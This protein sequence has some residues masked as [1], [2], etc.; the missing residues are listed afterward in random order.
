MKKNGLLLLMILVLGIVSCSNKNNPAGGA[1]YD[2]SLKV[3]SY[4]VHHCNPPSKPD[5]IDIDAIAN[6]IKKENPDLV[7]LQ[8]IDVKVNRSGKID[9]AAEIA[10]RAGFDHFYFSKAIDH[11]GG[12]YGVAIL[13]KYPVS[14]KRT[15]RLPTEPST[16]GEPRVLSLV[17]ISLPGGKALK[18]GSTHFDAQKESV[19]RLLQAK[20]IN[21]I[22]AGIEQPLIIAGDFNATEESEVMK[23]IREEFGLTCTNCA[24]TIPV[25]TPKKT[26][27][28]IAFRPKQS[29]EISSHRVIGEHYASDHLPVISVLKLR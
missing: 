25:V 24:P 5:L 10:K 16:K 14:E 15:F 18:F 26:I 2:S 7:A 4:N 17:T 1:V 28:F 22:A 27:D 11:D 29:F 23:I 9:Q 8:E 3:M 21:R 19:N 12:D 6:T 13:S 20:E